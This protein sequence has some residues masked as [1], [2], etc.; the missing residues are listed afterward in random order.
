L[1]APL[2]DGSTPS[3]SHSR[4]PSTSSTGIG[5][6]GNQPAFPDIGRYRNHEYGSRVDVFRI[7]TVLSKHIVKPTLALEKAI[8]D[9]YPS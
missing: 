1:R 6:F 2:S 8:A 7:F 5:R 3:A 4:S 9:H